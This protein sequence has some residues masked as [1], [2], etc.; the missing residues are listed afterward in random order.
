[1]I[2]IGDYVINKDEIIMIY[3]D[4]NMDLQDGVRIVFKDKNIKD[5][6]LIDYDIDDIQ[7]RGDLY[8]QNIP[9]LFTERS[10]I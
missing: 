10:T 3:N 4:K 2:I 5:I 8:E 1:M 7:L 9:R 6:F